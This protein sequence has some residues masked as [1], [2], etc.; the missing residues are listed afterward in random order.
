MIPIR[1]TT[2]ICP[3]CHEPIEANVYEEEGAVWLEKRC[4]EHGAFKDLV[5]SDY[6]LYRTFEARDVVALGAERGELGE[7]ELDTACPFACGLCTSHESQTVL[8]VIDVTERCNLNCP[9][10]FAKS[11]NDLAEPDLS[12]ESIKAIIDTFAAKTNASGLQFSGGEPTLRDDLPELIA[13]ARTKFEHVE[14]NTNGLKMAASANFCRAME[15]AGLS[16]AYLQFDGVTEEPYMKLRGR[17]LFE[18]K[19]QAIENHRLAGPKPAIVLV[20]TL[21]KGVNDHQIGDILRFAIANSDIVRGVN[22]QPVSFCGRTNHR[23][24]ERITV[25]DVV[26]CVA[27]QT[28]FLQCSDFYPPSVMSVLL[29]TLGKAEVGCHFSCGAFSYLVLDTDTGAVEPLT[30]YVDLERLADSYR[31]TG[32]ISLL[33]AL[34]TIHPGLLKELFV[35]FIKSRTYDDLSDLHFKLLF[36]G[37]MHFMDPYNFDCA[38]VRRCVIHYGLPDGRIIPFCA[39]NNLHRAGKIPNHKNQN[40]NKS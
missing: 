38:R 29:G 16:V 8:G 40:T 19:K 18:V 34:R 32:K 6:E 39:Y 4:A 23:P 3:V 10:C 21:V 28:D 15:S 14:V 1:P 35:S 13:Y 20:P 11:E 27:A 24:A 26:H 2:S 5:W 9:T 37:A 25:S 22:F 33:S 30:K 36:V 7:T 31:K 12:Q 17:K